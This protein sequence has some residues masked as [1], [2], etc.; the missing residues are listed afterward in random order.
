MPSLWMKLDMSYSWI[1]SED[2][3]LV[4]LCIDRVSRLREINLSSWKNLT[5]CGLQ[6]GDYA[7]GDIEIYRHN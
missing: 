6:V 1:Q 2:R 5:N 7:G 4:T 3:T